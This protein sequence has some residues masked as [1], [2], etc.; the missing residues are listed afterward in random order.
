MFQRCCCLKLTHL[1]F[2]NAVIIFNNELGEVAI[3]YLKVF[4]QH[5]H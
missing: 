1:K 2:E 3:E 5:L 4:I